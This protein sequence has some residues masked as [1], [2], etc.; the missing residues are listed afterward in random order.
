M[1]LEIAKSRVTESKF[2]VGYNMEKVHANVNNGT[3][4]SSSIYLR[5]NKN[6]EAAVN[7]SWTEETVM[8]TLE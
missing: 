4:L 5:V 1:K 2:A 8:L 7:L 3:E 6:L